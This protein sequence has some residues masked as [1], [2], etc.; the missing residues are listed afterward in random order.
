MLV[1][2]GFFPHMCQWWS[3]PCSWNPSLGGTGLAHY[4]PHEYYFLMYGIWGVG[5]TSHLVISKL[6]PL[7][8]FRVRERG[9]VL[10]GLILSLQR[11]TPDPVSNQALTDSP[12]MLILAFGRENS[13]FD[14][15]KQFNGKGRGKEM[16]LPRAIPPCSFPTSNC[17][18]DIVVLVDIRGIPGNILG[19]KCHI[20]LD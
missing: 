17:K 6:F 5:P 14:V 11:V 4:S 19:D 10:C 13:G 9:S 1:G 16:S 15:L 12:P 2:P 18:W 8:V 20:F 7:A 3:G